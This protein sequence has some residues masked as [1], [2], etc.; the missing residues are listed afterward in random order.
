MNNLIKF[1][2]TPAGLI[3]A[4][5]TI[6]GLALLAQSLTGGFFYLI[7]VPVIGVLLALI[8]NVVWHL[9]DEPLLRK[10]RKHFEKS[11]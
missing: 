7:V 8:I 5:A 3:C 6:I 11:E 4:G 9:L 2:F 10:I 1:L